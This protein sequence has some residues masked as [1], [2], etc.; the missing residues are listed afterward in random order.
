LIALLIVP[1]CALQ[2]VL[3]EPA[4]RMFLPRRW[5]DAVLPCQ[6]LTPGVMCNALIWPANGLMLAQGR[7]RKMLT[8]VWPSTIV[9]VMMLATLMWYGPTIVSVA[10]VMTRWH[11]MNSP[12]VHWSATRHV[13]PAYSFFR[14]TYRPLFSAAIAAIPCVLL[15]CIMPVGFVADLVLV[16]VCSGIF[17]AAYLLIM[18]WLAPADLKDLV[19]QL[20]PLLA[21][22]RRPRAVPQMEA[23]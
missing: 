20:A 5:L 3:V 9:L 6:I 7:F 17:A 8:V 18:S 11:L 16:I 2:I 1:F 10:G 12:Y 22:F 14:E 15:R 21:R 13:A 4:F 23:D 19:N